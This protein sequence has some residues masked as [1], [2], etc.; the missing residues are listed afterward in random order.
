MNK[1]FKKI[2]V[3]AVGFAMA[4]GVGVAVGSNTGVFRAE[5]TKAGSSYVEDSVLA[6]GG[7]IDTNAYYVLKSSSGYYY[8]GSASSNWGVTS[9]SLSNAALLQLGGT[10]SSLTILNTETSNYLTASNGNFAEST[11]SGNNIKLTNFTLSDVQ[12]ACVSYTNN[13]T[14]YLRCNHSSSYKFRWYKTDGTQNPTTTMT[15]IQLV[16]LSAVA[17]PTVTLNY[18]KANVESG[19][20]KTLAA[21]TCSNF[22]GNSTIWTSSN[23]SVCTVSAVDNLTLS[24]SKYNGTSTP[25]ITGAAGATTGSTVTINVYDGNDTSKTTSLASFVVTIGKVY[26]YTFTEKVFEDN[27]TKTL[28]ADGY[29][30]S[31]T[32]AGGGSWAFDGTK[33]QQLGS[34]NNPADGATLSTSSFSDYIKIIKINTSGNSS[35][36]GTISASVGGT[37]IG[38]AQSFSADP[39]EYTFTADSALAGTIQFTWNMTTVKGTYIKSIYLVMESAPVVDVEKVELGDNFSLAAGLT[40]QLIPE[41]NDGESIPT[42]QVM[43]YTSNHPEYAT[44]D[45][46]TGLV[47]AVAAGTAV[48]TGTAD[49]TS[50]SASDTVTV[51]VGHAIPTKLQRTKLVPSFVGDSFNSI[52]GISG[53]N[54]KITYSNTGAGQPV[55]ST[56][57]TN[58]TLYLDAVSNPSSVSDLTTQI[59]KDYAFSL[60]DNGKYYH[61]VYT[62]VVDNVSYSVINTTHLSGTN[63]IKEKFVFAENFTKDFTGDRTYLLVG[64]SAANSTLSIGYTNNTALSPTVVASSSNTNAITVSAAAID[65]ENHVVSTQLTPVARGNS[66]ITFTV[67]L[68]SDTF[69]ASETVSVRTSEPVSGD[70]Y[71]KVTDTDDIVNGHY[72]IVFEGGGKAFNGNLPSGSGTGKVD[73]ANNTID[74][75]PNN[76]SIAVSNETTNAEFIID[77][78][79]GKIQ[80]SKNSYYIYG[81]S[82]SNVL[83][84]TDSAATAGTTTFEIDGNG[85]AT[86]ISNTSQLAYNNASDQQRFRYAKSSA[87][88]STT[89]NSWR[90]IQLYILVEGEP[91]AEDL[92]FEFVDTYMKFDTV[93]AGEKGTGLCISAGWFSDAKAAFLNATSE[94]DKNFH[95]TA[96]AR[97]LVCSSSFQDAYDRLRAWASANTEE[98]VAIIEDQEVVDYTIRAKGPVGLFFKN[99]E[100]TNSAIV[101]TI[102]TIASLAAI[103][104]YFFL[105]KKKTF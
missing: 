86:I 85:D 49:D 26:E 27:E 61:L 44:V 59:T 23:T 52:S 53:S 60:S 67:T 54:I 99:T 76:D 58:V 75:T 3:A 83:N 20:S 34:N 24:N 105:R 63:E 31:W 5:A 17:T 79:N 68:G 73:S 84:S 89:G 18:T 65:T 7:T 25:T 94:Q 70:H 77:A 98:V 9:N 92:A 13:G 40:H 41:F 101:I 37:Q 64:D 33:G 57:Y 4:I 47:T 56:D 48:I 80:S 90:T 38:S 87:T 66:I 21:V 32:L 46:D 14:G 10:T 62:E 22:V 8:T 28:S 16:K 95:L 102:A 45:P 81:T 96:E 42:N 12:Y 6:V 30:P 74:V 19:K 55:T 97:L 15:P 100:S 91:T 82:G 88:I 1:L 78:D 71:E 103:G 72:L 43:H 50:H 2:A 51:T 93:P 29:N 104:G 36:V 35:V 39:A 69:A 11:T